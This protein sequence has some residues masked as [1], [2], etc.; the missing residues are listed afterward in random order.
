M[1]FRRVNGFDQYRIR[2][3]RCGHRVLK[4]SLE[5]KGREVVDLVILDVGIYSRSRDLYSDIGDTIFQCLWL[6]HNAEQ[7]DFHAVDT[8]V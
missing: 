6:G 7:H 1:I 8:E 2:L 4:A 3:A 5:R